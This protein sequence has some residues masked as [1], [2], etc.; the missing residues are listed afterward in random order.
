MTTRIR[1]EIAEVLEAMPIQYHAEFVANLDRAAADADR[2]FDQARDTL[3]A[4]GIHNISNDRLAPVQAYYAANL[5][6]H[7]AHERAMWVHV[8]ASAVPARKSA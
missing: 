6:K 5:A 8:L 4:L 2:A 7:E 3:K 1:V